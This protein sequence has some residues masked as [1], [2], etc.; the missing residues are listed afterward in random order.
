MG[1]QP[2]INYMMTFLVIQK[3]RAVW[4]KT[5]PIK[6]SILSFRCVQHFF[7]FLTDIFTRNFRHNVFLY[8]FWLISTW[9]HANTELSADHFHVNKTGRPHLVFFFNSTC[10][11]A[12]LILLWCLHSDDITK[13]PSNMGSARM[14]QIKWKVDSGLQKAYSKHIVLWFMRSLWKMCSHSRNVWEWS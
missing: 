7:F 8:I 3:I 11:G 5:G 2:Q 6:S 14:L 4:G 13:W 1:P 10:R 9:P 12:I